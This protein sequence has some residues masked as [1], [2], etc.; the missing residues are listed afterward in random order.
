MKLYLFCLIS[1]VYFSS[2]QA[3]IPVESSKNHEENVTLSFDACINEYEKLANH[4]YAKLLEKGSTDVGKSLHV[5]LLSSSSNQ[6]ENSLDDG[7]VNILI[8]NAIHPGEPCGVDASVM[9]VKTLLENKNLEEIL[10]KVN[11][12]II[13]MYNIGGGL[14]RGCCSRANQNGPMYYGFRGN[15][16]NLDLN[17]DF[18][19]CDSE[20][21]KS[22]SRYSYFKWCRL[23]VCYDVNYNS[24]R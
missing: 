14:N 21:A 6:N 17:R 4:K 11:I 13:P 3:Q 2:C 22:F 24:A 12:G 9:F 5:F 19:K 7:K 18:I 23:S 15:A 8:N 16:R 1:I 10:S 20:N